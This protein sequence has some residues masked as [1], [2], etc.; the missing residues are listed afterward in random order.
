MLNFI[1]SY[2]LNSVSPLECNMIMIYVKCLNDI[3]LFRGCDLF[4]PC[5]GVAW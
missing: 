2:K 1:V 3:V 4:P 5:K